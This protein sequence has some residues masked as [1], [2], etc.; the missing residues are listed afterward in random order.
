M[1]LDHCSWD[2]TDIEDFDF[3]EEELVDMFDDGEVSVASD[4]F[5]D[6]DII[7]K[8][9]EEAG[10]DSSDLEVLFTKDPEVIFAMESPS[11]YQIAEKL[12]ILNYAW[13]SAESIAMDED[14]YKNVIQV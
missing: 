6:L 11:A 5:V 1:N 4:E 9:V 8:L 14:F 2:E 13:I 10:N 7:K 3:D 12:G